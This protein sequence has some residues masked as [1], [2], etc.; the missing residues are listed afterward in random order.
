MA[1]INAFFRMFKT[2]KQYSLDA[3]DNKDSSNTVNGQKNTKNGRKCAQ[4]HKVAVSEV[5]CCTTNKTSRKALFS[6]QVN[7]VVDKAEYQSALSTL[8]KKNDELPSWDH[9]GGKTRLFRMNQNEKT[10]RH[11]AM[12][13]L[14]AGDRTNKKKVQAV[15]DQLSRDIR[16]QTV[17]LD[18]EQLAA[19]DDGNEPKSTLQPEGAPA[20]SVKKAES[21]QTVDCDAEQLA[22]QGDGNKPKSILKIE[23]APASKVKKTVRFASDNEPRK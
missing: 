23:G 11:L 22:T 8:M 18:A 21:S 2:Q 15:Y 10:M 20:S 7:V 16:A 17:E 12:D 4:N 14:P 6:R 9:H 1:S 3:S 13:L 19:K 5:V